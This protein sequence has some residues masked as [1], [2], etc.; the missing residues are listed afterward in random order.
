VNRGDRSDQDCVAHHSNQALSNN[1]K[2]HSG[3]HHPTRRA[4][5][6]MS[7]FPRQA[8]LSATVHAIRG[9]D[10]RWN[11]PNRP[12][13]RSIGTEGFG[14]NERSAKNAECMKRLHEML[15]GPNSTISRAVEFPERKL[16]R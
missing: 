10:W 4:V 8:I 6:E 16:D 11:A 13:A 1:R 3:E 14:L 7:G 9:D 15:A 2:S 12:V 5:P